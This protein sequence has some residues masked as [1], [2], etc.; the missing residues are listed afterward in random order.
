[1]GRL[2]TFLLLASLAGCLVLPAAA[3]A[4][5][6]ARTERL[7]VQAADAYWLQRG[8]SACPNPRIEYAALANRA[9]GDA[10]IGPAL[11]DAYCVIRVST[12]ISWRGRAGAIDFCWT[13]VHERGH[14]AGRA[15]SAAGIMREDGGDRPPP[16]CTR[17]F[18][19][20]AGWPSPA[21]RRSR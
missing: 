4:H 13:I 3:G 12:R 17:L 21:A 8:L 14:Q 20:R 9:A 18:S 5:A 6:S 2:A 16:V 15:H 10:F 7:S 11:P 19:A 1:M